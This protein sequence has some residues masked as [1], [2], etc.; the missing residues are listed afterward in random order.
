MPVNHLPKLNPDK[1]TGCCP[2]FLPAEWQN[3]TFE[4]KA[5]PFVRTTTHSLF[6]IPLDMDSMMT[7][8]M[9]A[10][11]ASEGEP[12]DEFVMLSRDL[13]P[14]RCEHYLLVKKAVP[15]LEN[16]TLSGTFLSQVYEGP[17]QN[18]PKWLEAMKT[19]VASKGKVSEK[20]YLYYTN[21]PKCSKFYGHNYVV[22]LAKIS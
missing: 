1:P 7:K 21:C 19:E 2:R 4:F 15:G 14:W 13:S 20:I 11:T 18:A 16:V 10:I 8:T 17:Y 3:Q 5:K 22:A 9:A 6:Y 12:K